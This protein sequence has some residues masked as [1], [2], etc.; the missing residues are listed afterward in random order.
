MGVDGLWKSIVDHNDYSWRRLS[1]PDRI[2]H[3]MEL[4]LN[5]VTQEEIHETALELWQKIKPVLTEGKSA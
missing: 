4:Q 2:A 1:Q 3:D 5:H